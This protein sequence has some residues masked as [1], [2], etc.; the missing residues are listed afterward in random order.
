MGES[1]SK[2]IMVFIALAIVGFLIVTSPGWN[3]VLGIAG[4]ESMA[5]TI[6]ILV[7]VVGGLYWVVS[8]SAK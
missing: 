2:W 4:Q 1:D 8:S 5:L 7:L 6:I 3:Q